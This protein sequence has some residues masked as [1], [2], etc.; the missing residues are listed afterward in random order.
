MNYLRRRFSSGDLSGEYADQQEA[1]D[2]SARRPPP[3]SISSTG[4]SHAQQQQ[5]QQQQNDLSLNLKPG[6]TTSAPSSPAKGASSI[7]QRVGSITGRAAEVVSGGAKPAYNKD[8]CKTLLVIDDQH[9]DWSKYF[10]GKR[11]H[12]DWD[13][14]VEQVGIGTVVF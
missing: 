13:I 12:G 3:T 10:R 5:Q 2:E 4:V 11:I 8:R 6:S 1:E 14:R 7:L 9:T